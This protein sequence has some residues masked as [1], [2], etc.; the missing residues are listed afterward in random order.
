MY[1][2]NVFNSLIKYCVDKIEIEIIP[3]F[4]KGGMGGF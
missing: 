1:T 2:Y 3:P 4:G